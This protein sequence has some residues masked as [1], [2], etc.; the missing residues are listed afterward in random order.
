MTTR[1]SW[2]LAL[3]LAAPATTPAATSAGPSIHFE[4]LTHDFG[5]IPAKGKQS[6]AWPYRNA[7]TDTL[8]IRAVVPS[9]GCT[10]TAAEPA[11][12][13]AGAAGTI[14]VTFDPEGQ[15]GSVR[16]TITVVTNDPASP[17]TILT[18][19]AKIAPAPPDPSMAGHPPITGQSLL[20]GS[21]GTCHAAP[22]A[23]KSGAA[24]WTAVCAMCHGA[25][26]SGPRAPSLRTPGYL[27]G[28]DDAFL[29]QAIAYG[30]SSTKMPGFSDVM[31]GPLTAA[32]V[33][34]LVRLLRSWGPA[35]P[36]APRR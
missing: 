15:S 1:S 17:H 32:Q 28:H 7:G 3:L 19:L 35:P 22:A 34:S 18:I 13:A 24:L 33:D 30:T 4:S 29:T 8:E 21:C 6:F 9:C 27:K 20:M 26:G 12:I 36:T 31:G 11:S 14:A 5:A 10:A 2:L 25:D 23:G 16:K